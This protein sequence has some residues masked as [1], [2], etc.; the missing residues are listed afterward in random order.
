MY[1]RKSN[2]KDDGD[3]L[4]SQVSKT[5][6][7]SET[8]FSLHVLYFYHGPCHPWEEES[9]QREG[10]GQTILYTCVFKQAIQ[11]WTCVSCKR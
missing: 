2:L 5:I 11:N 10:E 8:D 6:Q 1:F 7:T 4:L 3:V 9:L